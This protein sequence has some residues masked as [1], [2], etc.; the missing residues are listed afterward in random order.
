MDDAVESGLLGDDIDTRTTRV[1]EKWE[2]TV[3]ELGYEDGGILPDMD[4][5]FD[6]DSFDSQPFVDRLYD[7]V[8]SQHRPS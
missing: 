4:D 1:V 8:I 7:E 3:A 6:A 2:G 5:W